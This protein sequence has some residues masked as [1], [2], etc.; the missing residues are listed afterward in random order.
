VTQIPSLPV[1]DVYLAFNP[2][3]SGTTLVESLTQALPSSGSSNSYWTNVSKFNREFDT[4]SG[5]QHF[6]DRVEAGTLDIT[7]DNRTGYFFN[8]AA[9]SGIVDGN[10]SGYVIQPRMPIA[11]TGTWSGTTY[12]LFAGIIDSIQ[13]KVADEV[14]VDLAV[15]A[16]DLLKYLSLCYMTRQAF[17]PSYAN[18]TSTNAWFRVG[19]PVLAIVTSGVG[20]G[21]ST[22][23]QAQNSFAVGDNVTI[24]GLGITS[25]QPLNQANVVITSCNAMEF[26]VTNN[27]SRTGDSSGSG[28][29][30][31]SIIIDQLGGT[32]GNYLG[33]VSW[34]TYGA[35]IYDPDTCVDLTNGSSDSTGYIRLP[36][37]SAQGGL[38]F[39][40]LGLELGDSIIASGMSTTGGSLV[41]GCL[42]SGLF[43]IEVAST[44][45]TSSVQIN[46][47]YWHHI[48]AIGNSSGVLHGYVD[49]QYFSMGSNTHWSAGSNLI[50]GS[51]ASSLVGG[52]AAYVDEVVIS[53][54]SSL[55]TLATEVQNRYRAGSLLQL[56]F[57][58]TPSNNA[59][60]SLYTGGIVSS[61]DRIAEILCLA[62]FGTVS[63]G[64]ISA[65]SGITLISD[66]YYVNDGSA[67]SAGSGNGFVGTQPWYWDT[68]VT[69]S[70]AL[71]LIGQITDTDIGSFFQKPNG[72]LNFF[73]QSY[74]GTWAWTPSTSSGTWTVNTYTPSGDHVWTDDNSGYAYQG[75]SLQVV[76]DDA[77]I[78]TMVQVTPQAGTEQIYENTSGEARWGYST[79]T[80]TA[81][82]HTSLTLALST[83]T[84][85]GYLFQSPLPRVAQVTLTSKTVQGGTV[86]GQMT[87]I[88]GAG[89]GDVV[90]F[91]RTSPNASTSGTYPSV[92]AQIAANM[93]IESVDFKFSA[94]DGELKAVYQLDP[95]PVRS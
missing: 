7:F 85:L 42:A 47:G 57:P 67:W 53:N 95:Y 49:G 89:L 12:N 72:T 46:D 11:I 73:N 76:R 2:T 4:T 59:I 82:V 44:T 50:I 48:G 6:L 84:F 66:L 14:N 88:L 8:G 32:S 54:T 80:K 31:R 24:S 62:G 45:Y 35:M 79:L 40:V 9:P 91:K 63:G 15:Q 36:A 92:K 43:A 69:T 17:W 21:T 65:P 27:V 94:S 56:G 19:S 34:P 70:T 86:G 38:D 41:L 78:W 77:D 81:T 51:S 16:S 83:A 87:A 37:F 5:R 60:T 29:A 55:S 75:T 71:D 30:Y 93:V 61:G 13:E 18:S 74:Y 52:C 10:S 20:S 28:S 33:T 26:T 23:Y 90:E 58:V 22:T 3:Y 39:W 68:P 64:T 25:G 1:L